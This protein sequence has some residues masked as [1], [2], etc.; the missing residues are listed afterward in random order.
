MYRAVAPG[1]AV[2]TGAGEAAPT[3]KAGA[4]TVGRLGRSTV[5]GEGEFAGLTVYGEVHNGLDHPIGSV[6][7][8]VRAPGQTTR[9]GAV[10]LS[11]IPAGGDAPFLV[12]MIGAPAD[13]GSLAAVITGYSDLAPADIATTLSTTI[14]APGPVFVGDPDKVTGIRK[15]STS[16]LG[17]SGYVTNTG[18][19]PVHV[20]DVVVAYYGADGSIYLVA[21]TT[22]V[23]SQYP[24]DDPARLDPGSAGSFQV[25]V[26]RA[27]LLFV[28]EPSVAK[29]FVSAVPAAP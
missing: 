1:H 11:S 4:V 13:A 12:D 7:V 17:V 15:T 8:A 29:V 26:P 3:A 24:A 23:R 25:L 9:T 22:I 6:T 16:V 20:N 18:D 10:A 19:A 2:D 21:S 5:N 27:P 28:P 14:S